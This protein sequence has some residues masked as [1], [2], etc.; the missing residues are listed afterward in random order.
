MKIAFISNYL[1]HHQLPFCNA[2]MKMDNID[3]VF[4]A[5][6]PIDEER[7][8]MG[9]DDLNMLYDFVLCAYES[10]KKQIRCEKNL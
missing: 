8:K 6:E 1:T 7:V 2:I 9:Y 3:F 5:T 10:K 4:I